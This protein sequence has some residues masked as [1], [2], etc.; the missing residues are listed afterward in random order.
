MTDRGPEK[1]KP[2]GARLGRRD[3]LRRTAMASAAVAA[4]MIVPASALGRDGKVA[5]SNRIV[6][7][8]IGVGSQGTGNMQGFLKFP[9]AQIVAV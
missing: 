8:H 5:P 4:P 1:I 9:E 6:L 3:F 7:A 2:A